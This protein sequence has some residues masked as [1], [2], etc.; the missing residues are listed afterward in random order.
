MGYHSVID[1]K[2]HDLH[3]PS[4]SLRSSLLTL[5]A[6]RKQV[7]RGA[8][9][10]GNEWPLASDQKEHGDFRLKT[11]E[12]PSPAHIHGA[13]CAWRRTHPR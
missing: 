10:Q 8:H 3:L 2:G 7:A 11:H 12:D 4:R 5:H 6:L 9:K 1:R 13:I